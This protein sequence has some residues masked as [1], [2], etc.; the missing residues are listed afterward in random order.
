MTVCRIEHWSVVQYNADPYVAPELQQHQ[1]KGAVYGHRKLADGEVAISG[2]LVS[3]EGRRVYTAKSC[4][5]LGEPDP[6]Y[7][8]WLTEHGFTYDPEHPVKLS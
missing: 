7:L 5:E 8:A 2:D 1:L 6:A 4:Y 3:A